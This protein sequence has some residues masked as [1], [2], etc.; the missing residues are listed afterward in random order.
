MAPHLLEKI[1]PDCRNFVTVIDELLRRRQ[2]E[3]AQGDYHQIHFAEEW[4]PRTWSQTEM[5]DIV[6]SSYK[7]MRRGRITRPP[8]RTV[9][10]EISDYLNC[11]MS[12]RNRL[13]EAAQ[14][15]PIDIYITGERLIDLLQPTI[16]VAQA[17]S[18]PAMVINRDWHI[19][20]VNEQMLNLHSVQPDTLKSIPTDHFNALRMLIDPDLP[21]YMSLIDNK[22]SWTRMVRQTIYGFKLANRLCQF[23]NWY[24]D[25]IRDWMTLPEFEYHWK[26]VRIDEPFEDDFSAKNMPSAVLLNTAIPSIENRRFWLRPLIISTGY[27]QFDFPQIVAFL[28]AD[29]EAQNTLTQIGALAV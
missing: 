25:L 11:S 17:L 21:L 18:C 20:F 6:Y 3:L 4:G 26:T 9:V 2:S 16:T 24:Q 13:L 5:E 12:E 29:E 14:F 10:M 8:K 15:A 7:Q 22:P 27:F 23:E 1:H 19:H 28:P